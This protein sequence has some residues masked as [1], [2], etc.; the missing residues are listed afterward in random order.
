MKETLL[1]F[2]PRHSGWTQRNVTHLSKAGLLPGKDG[3]S[4]LSAGDFPALN[5]HPVPPGME[6]LPPILYVPAVRKP[7]RGWPKPSEQLPLMDFP[8]QLVARTL[9][10]EDKGG[11]VHS[12]GHSPHCPSSEEDRPL[13]IPRPPFPAQSSEQEREKSQLPLFGNL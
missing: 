8:L 10:R 12:R 1:V 7:C 5:S 2:S 4:F 11:R 6:S 13:F 9:V 3:G